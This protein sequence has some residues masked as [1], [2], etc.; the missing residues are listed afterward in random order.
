MIFPYIHHRLSW[1][2]M[3]DQMQKKKVIIAQAGL[4]L[5]YQNITKG[6]RNTIWKEYFVTGKFW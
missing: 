3:S 5:I 6:L 1:E 2:L 4:V